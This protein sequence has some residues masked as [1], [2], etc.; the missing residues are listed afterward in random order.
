MIPKPDW[1]RP[2]ET[3]AWAAAEAAL[4][5]GGYLQLHRADFDIYIATTFVSP[6]KS[7]VGTG[8]TFAAALHELA[9]RLSERTEPE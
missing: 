9:R 3:W 8:P 7:A 5:E 2:G 4:P 1:G 6:G